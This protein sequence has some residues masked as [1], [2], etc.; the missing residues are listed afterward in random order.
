MAD[1]SSTPRRLRAL[2][3]VAR[4]YRLAPREI[5]AGLWFARCPGCPRG[6]RGRSLVLRST[7]TGARFECRLCGVHGGRLN[8]LQRIAEGAEGAAND[9]TAPMP[10]GDPRATL[11]AEMAAAVARH[12]DRARTFCARLAVAAGEL[13][14]VEN[15][16]I[17]PGGTTRHGPRGVPGLRI[18]QAENDDTPAPALDVCRCP[19]CEGL[20]DRGEGD[21]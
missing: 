2:V 7:P 8:G 21:A 14:E 1:R 20:D 13:A 19:A 6:A 17:G 18:V 9:D 16:E 4:A 11:R 15:L 3:A 12:G 10:V 5:A